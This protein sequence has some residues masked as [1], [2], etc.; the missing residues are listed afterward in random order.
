MILNIVKE[1]YAKRLGT[2]DEEIC[3]NNVEI[4]SS[5]VFLSINNK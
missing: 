4:R 3:S 5:G 1:K 2:F